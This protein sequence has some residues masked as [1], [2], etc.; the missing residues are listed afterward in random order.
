METI[1][2]FF[3]IMAR[4]KILP[5]VFPLVLIAV[6]VCVTASQQISCDGTSYVYTLSELAAFCSLKCVSVGS[7]NVLSVANM[8]DFSGCESIQTIQAL[9]VDGNPNLLSFQG[10]QNV[11]S[12]GTMKVS[13]NPLL[14]S[15]QSLSSLSSITSSFF[16]TDNPSVQTLGLKSLQT[17]SGA[18]SLSLSPS[19]TS[20]GLPVMTST[21][22]FFIHQTALTSFSEL[23]SSL[24]TVGGI[25][26]VNNS[27]LKSIDISPQH[28]QFV[29]IANNSDLETMDGLNG[30]TQATWVEVTLNSILTSFTG[31][32]TPL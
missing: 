15:L 22:D 26:I 16:L 25:S 31:E 4:V 5:S 19:L 3:F 28:S 23:S 1:F 24:R 32:P 29:Q 9:Q 30:A 17:V 8:T 13:S 6:S 20:F 14:T 27:Y 18:F 21:G 2:V 12:I 10:L 7:L 11:Q